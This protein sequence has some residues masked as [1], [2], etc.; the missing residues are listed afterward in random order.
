MK[1]L[2]F[3]SILL[4]TSTSIPL[5][6]TAQPFTYILDRKA[7]C[8]IGCA[9]SDNVQVFGTLSTD[10]LA[11]SLV[12][13]DFLD[14]RLTFNSP[15]YEKTTL[16]PF[17]SEIV[18]VSD[19]AVA[20]L[21]CQLTI[22]ALETDNGGRF[23]I[24]DTQEDPYQVEYTVQAS[25]Q[26][27]DGEV[28]INAPRRS[29]MDRLEQG[30]L[31]FSTLPVVVT[32]P[33]DCN[34]GNDCTEDFCDLEEGCFHDPV[35]AGEDCVV[36][37]EE[38]AC[39]DVGVCS[40]VG[41]TS[42]TS[43]TVEPIS[44]ITKP[45]TTDSST[46]EEGTMMT[47]EMMMTTTT[48][49]VDAE[50]TNSSTNPQT[51]GFVDDA[52]NGECS[53]PGFACAVFL[54]ECQCL[55]TPVGPTEDDRDVIDSGCDGDELFGKPCRDSD[56]CCQEDRFCG[57]CPTTTSIA[58]NPATTTNDATTTTAATSSSTPATETEESGDEPPCNPTFCQSCFHWCGIP[59]YDCDADAGPN[60]CT[61]DPLCAV[62]EIVCILNKDGKCPGGACPT[63]PKDL[64]C[65]V[66][67]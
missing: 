52:C 62:C 31:A 64:D 3:A 18:L 12:D 65:P 36:N 5:S 22:T 26:E 32:L 10:K 55:P 43:T 45:A 66:R 1:L 16:A 47:G 54:G 60:S 35:A 58:A 11:D 23:S 37:G 25:L 38:G 20:A 46:R 40:A 7:P 67:P 2:P 24:Q 30:I 51:C 39:N 9:A 27:T 61:T 6:A 53:E 8:A 42:T 49:F 44:M 17:N 21:T 56:G 57:P 19:V 63:D 29:D 59:P 48:T 33:R 14:W 34:D 50:S 13:G 41:A 28:I 4:A 15:S